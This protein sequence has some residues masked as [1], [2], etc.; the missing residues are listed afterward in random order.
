MKNTGFAQGLYETSS[1]QKEVLGM[2]RIEP[3]GRKF[4]YA[5]AGAADLGAGKIGITVGVTAH[6]INRPV[7]AAVAIG[8]TEV[9]VTVS[10]TLVTADMY[11]DGYLQI[12]DGTGQGHNYLIDTNSAC[13]SAGDTVV[14]L[15]DPVR[16]ALVA[17]ATSQVSLIP[18]PWMGVTE[19]ATSESG[20]A[21]IPLLA[22]T[23]LYYYWCQTGG[24][25]CCLAEGSD[26]MG[27]TLELGA[28]AGAV[29]VQAGYTC[30][31]VGT[32]IGTAF[33]GAEYKPIL[34][35]LD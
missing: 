17:S 24:I 10:T 7:A 21:G 15:K 27:T 1:S 25:A 5:K 11:K 28:G 22:V 29:K 3:D 32:L 6:H 19:S 9:T 18:N 8:D 26:A 35:Q 31:F 33:I 34:L 23:T 4:R 13:A 16:V 12:N 20:P 14:T 30:G 2:L